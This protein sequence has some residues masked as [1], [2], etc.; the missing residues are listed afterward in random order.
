L[1]DAN[2]DVVTCKVNIFPDIFGNPNDGT[3]L[4]KGSQLRLG[5][6]S[7]AI[8]RSGVTCRDGDLDFTLQVSYTAL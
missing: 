6:N 1:D 8:H 5:T 3:G 4:V 2:N 7:M